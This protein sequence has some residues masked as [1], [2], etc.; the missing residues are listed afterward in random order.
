MSSNLQATNIISI[1]ICDCDSRVKVLFTVFKTKSRSRGNYCNEELIAGEF[2]GILRAMGSFSAKYKPYRQSDLEF[3]SLRLTPRY[4][5][6]VST[7]NLDWQ[8]GL[9]HGYWQVI[10]RIRIVAVASIN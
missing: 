3:V 6:F 9:F 10:Y 2:I 7:C 5:S 1:F 4:S 8:S